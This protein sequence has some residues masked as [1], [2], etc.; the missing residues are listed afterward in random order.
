MKLT[1]VL[2]VDDEVHIRGALRAC[3]VTAGYDVLEAADGETAV[4]LAATA[5][6]RLVVLDLG[7]PA[8]NGNEVIRRLRIF[9]SVPILVLSA[10]DRDGDKVQALDDGADDYVTKPFSVDELL[11]RVRALLRRG[12][13]QPGPSSVVQVGQATV[14]LV[15]HSVE[16]A[17]IPVRLTAT[18]WALLEV[19]VANP[20]KLLTRKYLIDA[21]WGGSHGSEASSLRI[22][23]SHLR[24]VIEVEP[25]DP[26]HLMTET[27]AGYRLVAVE[28]LSQ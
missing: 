12:E 23:V 5:M 13:E 8:M 25:A 1:T 14:D 17:G 9:S 4:H 20:G 6:P 11:A 28:R 19:F 22:Y 27:G 3:L 7:L 18:E 10:R 24:R 16:V 26:Q 21:V 15:A 2:I